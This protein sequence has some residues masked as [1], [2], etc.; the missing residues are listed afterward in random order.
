MGI[1]SLIGPKS[2]LLFFAKKQRILGSVCYFLG[3]GLIVIGWFLLTTLGF[4]LQMYGL[5]HLFKQFLPTVFSYMQTVPVIGPIIRNSNWVH[6][7]VDF[8]SGGKQ[9]KGGSSA[10]QR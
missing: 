1:V 4:M 8:A 3:F 6:T 2:T 10:T 5:W 9:A 7:L